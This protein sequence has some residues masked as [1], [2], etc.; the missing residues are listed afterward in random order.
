M[1]KYADL[2]YV[3]PEQRDLDKRLVN[4]AK[5]ANVYG[6]RFVQP[7]FK[8]YRPTENEAEG[9]AHSGSIP[10]DS[11]DA[12]KI[13]KGVVQLPEKHKWA[14]YWAYRSKCNPTRACKVIGVSRDGL[15]ALIQDGRQMLLNRQV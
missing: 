15:A 13:E 2:S 4:W 12:L 3:P 14:V 9:H 10:V 7:M 11:S 6:G 1:R 8:L 5:W